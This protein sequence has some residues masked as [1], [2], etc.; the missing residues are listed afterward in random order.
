MATIKISNGSAVYSCVTTSTK[1]TTPSLKVGDVYIPCFK[2]NLNDTVT[3]AEYNYTLGPLKVN[4]YRCAVGT[5]T[6]TYSWNRV[7][8]VENSLYNATSSSNCNCNCSSIQCH[9]NC[10]C[11]CSQCNCSNCNGCGSTNCQCTYNCNCNCSAITTTTKTGQ[12]ACSINGTGVTLTY[13]WSDTSVSSSRK[14]R[15]LTYTVKTNN[16]TIVASGSRTIPGQAGT[17]SFSV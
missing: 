3:L 14:A 9:C 16:G 5:R 15:T 1:L 7:I 10:N 13:S 4:G 12:L 2:G 8:Y 11:G 6:L 17:Q